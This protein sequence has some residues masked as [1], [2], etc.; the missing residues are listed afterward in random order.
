MEFQVQFVD[1]RDSW[2][3]SFPTPT[4]PVVFKFEIDVPLREQLP[5]LKNVLSAPLDVSV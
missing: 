1:D 2:R 4:V 3:L 5:E